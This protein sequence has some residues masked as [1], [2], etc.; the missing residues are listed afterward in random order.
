MTYNVLDD[1]FSKS[2]QLIE[3]VQCS[4]VNFKGVSIL[5]LMLMNTVGVDKYYV[6]SVIDIV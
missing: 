2:Y 1:I 3:L 6:F 4:S 5:H